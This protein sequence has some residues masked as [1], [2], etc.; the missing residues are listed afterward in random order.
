MSY[1]TKNFTEQGGEKT[2]IGGKV[3]IESG[4]EVEIKEGAEVTGLPSGGG[5]QLYKHTLKGT[6]GGSNKTY[7]IISFDPTPIASL[8]G[9]VDFIKTKALKCYRDTSKQE[10]LYVEQQT[11]SQLLGYTL[12]YTTSPAALS[13]EIFLNTFTSDT[14]TEL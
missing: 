8:S 7:I 2:V 6:G 13:S 1:N 11:E 3:V 5:T 10:Y 4:A 14:V 12:A 9:V